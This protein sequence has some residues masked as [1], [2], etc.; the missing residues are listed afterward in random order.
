MIA[1][2]CMLTSTVH[3][4]A[5][6]DVPMQLQGLYSKRTIIEDDVWIGWNSIVL[7]G[8]K[9]GRGAII[10]ACS[11]VTKDVAPFMVAAGNPAKIIKAR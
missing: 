2:Y 3:N 11:V 9:I 1:S 4:N 6:L 5:Y 7:P 10:G 8:V